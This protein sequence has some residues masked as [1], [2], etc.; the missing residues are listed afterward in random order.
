[1]ILNAGNLMPPGKLSVKPGKIKIIVGPEISIGEM[2]LSNVRQLRDLT[3]E[4]MKTMIQS[5]R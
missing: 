4:R 1:V 5:T 3:F 2:T